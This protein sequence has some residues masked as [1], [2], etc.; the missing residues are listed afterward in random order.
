MIM[1]SEVSM[2]IKYKTF[3]TLIKLG[4]RA[5]KDCN[6]SKDSTKLSFIFLIT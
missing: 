2:E 5:N 3:L 4:G 6:H 1:S